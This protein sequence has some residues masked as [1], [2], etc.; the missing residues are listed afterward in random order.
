MKTMHQP[1]V[2]QRVGYHLRI[3]R[4]IHGLSQEAA[5]VQF[6]MEAKTWQRYEQGVTALHVEFLTQLGDKWHTDLNWLLRDVEY[7]A[8]PSR[9]KRGKNTIQ[10]PAY[11]PK[12]ERD[13]YHPVSCPVK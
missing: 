13:T 9:V 8:K 1:T 5:A 11:A 12:N 3:E 10:N 7:R 4:L 2:N 6:N